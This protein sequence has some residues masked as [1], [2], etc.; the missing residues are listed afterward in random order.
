LST[1]WNDL[2]LRISVISRY[3][4]FHLEYLNIGYGLYIF[5]NAFNLSSWQVLGRGVCE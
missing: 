4:I 1:C 5:V 3:S 2:P